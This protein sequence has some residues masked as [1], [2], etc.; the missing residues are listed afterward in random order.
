MQQMSGANFLVTQVGQITGNF[1]PKVEPYSALIVNAIQF[2]A[3]ASSVLLLSRIGRKPILHF[4][5]AGIGVI[6][7]ILGILFFFIY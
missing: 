1:D 3:T 7:L 4:G 2:I 5:N 6:N